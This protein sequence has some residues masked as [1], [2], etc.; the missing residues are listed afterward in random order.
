[1]IMV[2]NG[3]C[4]GFVFDKLS[5]LCPSKNITDIMEVELCG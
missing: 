5:A 3:L 4:K 2:Y 1:M